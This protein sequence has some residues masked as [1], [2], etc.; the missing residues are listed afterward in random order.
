M[1]HPFIEHEPAGSEALVRELW[2]ILHLAWM[3]GSAE[4]ICITPHLEPISTRVVRV[5]DYIA[6]NA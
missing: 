6:T 2:G 4:P 3:Q 5:Q 1:A